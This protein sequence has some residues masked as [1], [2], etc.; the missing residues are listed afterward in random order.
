[1]KNGSALAVV[2]GIQ[3]GNSVA[4]PTAGIYTV[5]TLAT[6]S[7]FQGMVAAAQFAVD[8]AS[9]NATT[10][11]IEATSGT[12]TVTR[13]DATGYTGTFDLTFGTD[14]VTGTFNT[15]TCSALGTVTSFTCPP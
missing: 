14:H 8:D 11:P 3:S 9:C 2:F 12:L 6:I 13:V 1:L 10:G 7:G 5:H 4:P 15:G